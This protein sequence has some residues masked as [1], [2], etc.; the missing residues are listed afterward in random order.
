MIGNAYWIFSFSLISVTDAFNLAI[1]IDPFVGST[2]VDMNYGGYSVR[3]KM[4]AMVIQ[5]RLENYW[6]TRHG[7]H[8]SLFFNIINVYIN[9]IS[10][11]KFWI[12]IICHKKKIIFICCVGCRYE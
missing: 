2:A 8:L 11:L 7:N 10:Y 9:V 6:A 3:N 4:V 12:H 1:D 5:T